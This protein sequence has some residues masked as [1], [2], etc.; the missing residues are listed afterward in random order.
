M[1]LVDTE[2]GEIHFDEELK[3]KLA[4][5]YPYEKWIQQN[6]VNLEEI[7]TGQN[8]SPDMGDQFQKCVTSFNFS[9]E[10]IDRI[11]KE[12]ASTGKEPIG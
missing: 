9:L 7:E 10:D 12:M 8:F 6:M 5:E 1:L 3:A 2:A 11:I 4:N